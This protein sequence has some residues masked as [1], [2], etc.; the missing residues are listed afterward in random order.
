MKKL[1]LI[2]L[3]SIPAFM[4]TNAQVATLW[5]NAKDLRIEGMGWSEGIRD[6]TR[7][8]E[9]FSSNVISSVWDLSAL[10]SG[11]V[12]RFNVKNTT[13]ISAKWTLRI[14]RT[15]RSMVNMSDAG[16]SGVDLYVKKDGKWTWM[17]V[18]LPKGT[19]V[20]Q[21]EKIVTGLKTSED[22]E[23]MLCLPLYNGVSEL[24]IGTNTAATISA[25]TVYSKKP[26]VFY[27]TSILQGACSSRPGMLFSSMLGRHFDAPVINLGF[28]GEGKMEEVFGSIMG[29]IDASAYFL[30]C[31]QNMSALGEEE[32]RKRTLALVRKLKSLKAGTPIV[33]VE[34]AP[35]WTHYYYSNDVNTSYYL[36]RG[37]KNAYNELI[38]EFG[39][40]H[41][42]E[43]DNMFPN[44]E[45]TVDNT[46][47]NDLG[48][49]FYFEGLKN[50][51]EQF[52]LVNSQQA[53][54]HD[55]QNIIV[56]DRSKL[57]ILMPGVVE[58][59]N[60]QGVCISYQ[61][62]KTNIDLSKHKGSVFVVQLTA[63]DGK[64]TVKKIL[65]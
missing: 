49:Y 43:A 1:V 25:A 10:S 39:D 59:F 58:I 35:K 26:L 31:L 60:L 47:P 19:G 34:N 2:F 62:D 8:P 40:I 38:Q 50:V 52:S 41:Y 46:H 30:D 14:G 32:V 42:V 33:L 37:L 63:Q 53:I 22:Y 3:F 12:V 57:K 56:Q 20:S 64:Q 9:R 28:S 17:G 45:F 55:E 44:S 51:I 24:H 6:Y 27:G 7:L 21:E 36:R 48:M 11:I 61:K 5:T 29:E 65:L 4:L 54:Q 13:F 15:N 18:G 23:L 16:I